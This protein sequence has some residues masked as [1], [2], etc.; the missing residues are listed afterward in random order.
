MRTRMRTQVRPMRLGT[1]GG[2]VHTRDRHA[3]RRHE[4]PQPLASMPVSVAGGQHERAIWHP[5]QTYRGVEKGEERKMNMS[6]HE[7]AVYTVRAATV[8]LLLGIQMARQQRA[9]QGRL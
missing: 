4:Q 7:P 8:D 6:R 5:D 2:V 9:N 1:R 3:A